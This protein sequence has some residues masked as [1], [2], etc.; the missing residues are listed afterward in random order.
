MNELPLVFVEENGVVQDDPRF[1]CNICGNGADFVVQLELVRGSRK[2]NA[3]HTQ[4]MPFY[5]CKS[6]EYV[7]KK[8]QQSI[9][10]KDF[11]AET[12]KENQ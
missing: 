6:H 8:M 12:I 1:K 2:Y 9:E 7:Y 5:L 10:L 3:L 4:Q 11:F